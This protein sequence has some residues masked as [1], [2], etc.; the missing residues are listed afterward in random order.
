[1]PGTAPVDKKALEEGVYISLPFPTGIFIHPLKSDI[2]LCNKARCVYVSV[3]F[4]S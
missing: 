2:H 3:S 1:M 4:N